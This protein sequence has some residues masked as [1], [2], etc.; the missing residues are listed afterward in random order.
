MQ[1]PL[2]ETEA[3]PKG[4]CLEC[5]SE[6]GRASGCAE[7]LCLSTGVHPAEPVLT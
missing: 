1:F 6:A 3:T 5:V 7:G 2:G 4:P